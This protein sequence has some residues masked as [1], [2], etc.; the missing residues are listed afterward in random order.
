MTRALLV[1][2]TLI[3]LGLADVAS[4][5]EYRL[6]F[7]PQSGARNAVVAGYQFDV[8]GNVVGNCSYDTYSACSGRGCRST[9][10]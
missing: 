9:T 3:G 2:S 7:S 4:A 5:Y 6:Q 10:A 8:S 1:L